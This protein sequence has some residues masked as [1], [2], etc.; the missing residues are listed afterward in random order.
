MFLV[1]FWLVQTNM[2]FV[3]EVIILSQSTWDQTITWKTKHANSCKSPK[4][5][6]QKMW[7]NALTKNNTTN[8][9]EKNS[10]IEA[11][12]TSRLGAQMG[13]SIIEQN[14]KTFAGPSF[15]NV[16]ICATFGHCKWSRVSPR[17]LFS[18]RVMP[19]PAAHYLRSFYRLNDSKKINWWRK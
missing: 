11:W 18:T 13:K 16:R 8:E 12:K 2:T 3:T 4:T 7:L 6:A 9:G 19:C 10:I 5:S 14:L 15:W 1:F 17:K